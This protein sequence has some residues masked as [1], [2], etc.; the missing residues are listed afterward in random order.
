[1]HVNSICLC[2]TTD[3]VAIQWA[4]AEYFGGLCPSRAFGAPRAYGTRGGAIGK[5]DTRRPQ[6]KRS[7]S[8]LPIAALYARRMRRIAGPKNAKS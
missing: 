5:A 2:V 3:I 1:M 4:Q 6:K 7:V 8:A